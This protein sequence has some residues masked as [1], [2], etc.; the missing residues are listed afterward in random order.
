MKYVRKIQVQFKLHIIISKKL[1]S[2]VFQNAKNRNQNNTI[3]KLPNSNI[4]YFLN[5][6]IKKDV[7]EFMILKTNKLYNIYYIFLDPEIYGL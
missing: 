4:N 7:I 3:I 2:I 1:T 5:T 6:I